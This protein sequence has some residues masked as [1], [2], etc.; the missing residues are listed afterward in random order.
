MSEYDEGWKAG[1]EC[2]LAEIERLMTVAETTSEREILSSLI[3]H[4]R[5][6]ETIEL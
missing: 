5:L 4:L 3:K 6:K 1:E 2:L